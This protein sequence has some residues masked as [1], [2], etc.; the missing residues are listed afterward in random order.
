M[1]I[2]LSLDALKQ[3]PLSAVVLQLRNIPTKH[4]EYLLIKSIEIN[5]IVWKIKS[6]A[7]RNIENDVV[8]FTKLNVIDALVSPDSKMRYYNVAYMNDPIEGQVIFD[9]ID[10][11][12]I[13]KIYEQ[14][15]ANEPENIFI[16][17]FVELKQ[18]DE[19]IMWRTYGKN[20][21]NEEAA[22]GNL[23][24][25]TQYFDNY[26]Q[27]ILPELEYIP[28]LHPKTKAHQI[29]YRVLYY[30]TA[31]GKFNDPFS[32]ELNEEFEK[33]NK[34]IT[35]LLKYKNEKLHIDFE[36]AINK[37]VYF[38]VSELRHLI[39]SSD[40]A[41]ENELRVIQHSTYERTKID[42]VSNLPKK[43]YVES[44]KEIFPFIKKILLGPKVE[45]KNEWLVYLKA[46]IGSNSKI[47]IST[48]SKKYR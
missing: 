37:I 43:L 18:Q 21:I 17:S 33:L 23:I 31:L 45:K 32:K 40:F 7:R 16:G 48:S 30:N 15:I 13:K 8:H 11:G 22:G 35:E 25:E 2:D 20:E 24:I 5:E 9:C 14:K 39:K 36:T 47:E 26:N 42:E 28:K 6:Y 46:K 34:T 38:F 12:D 3:I 1:A 44:N 29:L 10:N 19:L 41:L 27:F 4:T